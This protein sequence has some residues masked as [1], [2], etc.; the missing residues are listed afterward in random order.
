MTASYHHGDLKAALVAYA[1]EQLENQQFEKLSM[2][3]MAKAIGVSH[4]AAYRHFANKQALLDAVAIQG[5]EE[6]L[7]ECQRAVQ[8]APRQA[9]ARLKACGL[10]YVRYGVAAPRVQAH[11]F[12]A[13]SLPGASVELG[14]AGQ[15]LFTLLRSLVEEGQNSDEFREGDTRELAHACWAMVHGLA[16]L[17]SVHALA[18]PTDRISHLPGE[19]FEAK[20]DALRSPSHTRNEITMLQAGSAIDLL[21]DGLRPPRS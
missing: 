6:M 13:V 11:M 12:D 17:L 7:A 15:R 9:R 14:K 16:S 18:A 20:V 5:F 4:T 10:A 3:E 19:P 2:R 1:R 21:L 8:A